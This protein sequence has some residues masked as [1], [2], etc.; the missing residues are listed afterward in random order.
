M[1]MSLTE[2]QSNTQVD[3]QKQDSIEKM[4]VEFGDDDVAIQDLHTDQCSE[5]EGLFLLLFSFLIN[6]H[7][8]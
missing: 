2:N 3:D 4:S 7:R 6:V 5:E 1:G 8:I